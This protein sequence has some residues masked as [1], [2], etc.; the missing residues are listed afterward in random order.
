M[1]QSS[2]STVAMRG[3][4]ERDGQRIGADCHVRRFASNFNVSTYLR[5]YADKA[6]RAPMRSCTLAVTGYA[7]HR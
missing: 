3:A 6:V 7:R 1:L 5:I 4:G 2:R